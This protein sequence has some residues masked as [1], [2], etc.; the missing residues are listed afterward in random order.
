MRLLLLTLKISC[1]NNNSVDKSPITDSTNVTASLSRGKLSYFF[2]YDITISENN[3][4]ETYG[5]LYINSFL[6]TPYLY[7]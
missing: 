5:Y 1:I 3:P 2:K 7:E 4:N 6:I